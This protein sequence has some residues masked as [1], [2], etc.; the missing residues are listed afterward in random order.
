MKI[1][2]YL[3][4]SFIV[5]LVLMF[6]LTGC[7]GGDAI[8]QSTTKTTTT[9]QEL[10]DL[11]KAHKEGIISDKEYAEAREKILNGE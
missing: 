11:D 10:V 3:A 5:M 7:G 6:G 4:R 1:N 2:V 9:G 8:T